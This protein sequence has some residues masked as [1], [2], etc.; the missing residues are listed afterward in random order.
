MQ[1]KFVNETE[2]IVYIGFWKREGGMFV[3]E[4]VEAPPTKDV[5]SS[6]NR[7]LG[8][9]IPSTETNEWHIVSKNFE[10]LGK[11]RY[12][13]D[14]LGYCSPGV[15]CQEPYNETVWYWRDARE[16]NILNN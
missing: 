4:Y 11:F 3:Y 10:R 7:V 2:N 1:Y 16:W 13:S 12:K 8:T 9:T 14:G 5:F 15:R 6:D